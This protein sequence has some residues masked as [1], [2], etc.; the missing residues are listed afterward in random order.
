MQTVTEKACECES[1]SIEYWVLMACLLKML[2][3]FLTRYCDF[4]FAY[5]Q[6]TNWIYILSK[7]LL[8]G[9][10]HKSTSGD[11]SS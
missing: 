10:Y 2:L 4:L 5:L 9:T 1:M 7:F 8:A 11:K 3:L 6:W